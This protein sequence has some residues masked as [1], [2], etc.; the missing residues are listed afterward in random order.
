[1]ATPF[2]MT[3]VDHEAQWQTKQ[4]AVTGSPA[5]WSPPTEPILLKKDAVYFLFTAQNLV[6]HPKSPLKPLF[7]AVLLTDPLVDLRLVDVICKLLSFVEPGTGRN[8]VEDSPSRA[9]T[10]AISVLTQI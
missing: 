10:L 7:R 9:Y 8:E 5:K 6:R 1:M 3:A 2:E 4:L